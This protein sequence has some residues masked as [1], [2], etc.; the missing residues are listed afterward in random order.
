MNFFERFKLV[1]SGGIENYIFG[2]D[3]GGKIQSGVMHRLNA[4]LGLHPIS[5]CLPYRTYDTETQLFHNTSAKGFLLK[6]HPMHGAGPN[7]D[8]LMYDLLQR[9][10]PEGAMVQ[11]LLYAS[12]R[13]GAEFDA[14][15]N[16]R[17]GRG[18]ILEK[19]AEMRAAFFKKGAHRSIIPG[20]DYILRDFQLYFSVMF[21][22][23]MR[24]PDKMLVSY[25][26]RLASGFKSIGMRVETVE[27]TGLLSLVDELLRPSDSLYPSQLPWN[28]REELAVQLG[29]SPD[30]HRVTSQRI[31]VNEGDWEIRTFK[32]S[33]YPK[34]PVFLCEMSDYIGDLF[35]NTKRIGCPFVYSFMIRILKQTDEGLKIQLRSRTALQRAK[36][37][38]A[39]SQAA[40]EEA[41]FWRGIV[42]QS[43]KKERI[44]ECAFQITLYC[45]KE[46]ADI[47]EA[48]LTNVFQ[49]G[50]KIWQLQK[51]TFLHF[52]SLLAHLPLAQSHHLFN[53]LR[54]LNLTYKMWAENAANLFPM[55]GEIKGHSS[56]RLMVGQRR[57]QILFWDPFDNNRGNYNV[58]ITGDSGSGKSVMMQELAFSIVGT[59]GRAFIVDVGKSYQKLCQLLDG[60]FLEFA[61]IGD[62]CLNPFTN[63]DFTNN[64][65]VESFIDF[66]VP[67]VCTLADPDETSLGPIQKSFV[68]AAIQQV[69]SLKKNLSDIQDI[70]DW[71]NHQTDIRANDI[72][73]M[74]FPYSLKG[75]YAGYFNGASSIDFDNPLVVFELEGVNE[76][77]Q[78]AIFKLL[79]F[80]VTEKMYFGSRQQ[81]IALMIDEAWDMLRG[82]HGAKII[83]HVARRA[84]K[85]K[86][87]LLVAT[88]SLADFFSSPA[89]NAVY[90]QSY[91]LLLLMQK[92]TSITQALKNDEV[93]FSA[94]QEK[95]MR[96]VT[97]EQGEY[98]EIMIQGGNG[99]FAVGR[100]L[101]DP[102]SRV[103]YS[104][105]PDDYARVEALR[106]QGVSM[107]Q[108]IARV[109]EINF[110]GNDGT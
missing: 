110:G 9:L 29:T 8:F 41:H 11:V 63:V 42:A 37:M 16:A 100:L 35:A 86:G 65:Q 49:Q 78:A 43:E 92:D 91:W 40:I 28:P 76:R 54:S 32:V 3:V 80:H 25:R 23:T 17:Q 64:K 53:D 46:N 14:F 69:V 39:S 67:F 38:A 97:T 36:Q 68:N 74:L 104:T 13:I 84:R 50:D 109:A 73:L 98:S 99:E 24:M 5:E 1:I 77:L 27:P 2:D 57:G 85:Y 19:N 105:Q 56:K 52:P 21:D 72:G 83:E 20:Q 15:A 70:I 107:S 61:K 10:L 34:N 96:S 101:L 102:Y 89:G 48:N 62:I 108:T 47:E 75:Q 55:L 103:L 66:M 7:D 31:I 45:K 79:L 90:K 93:K 4:F 33:Q 18:A 60:V 22:E 82:G 12:P 94:F 58:A 87:C 106:A 51:N 26:K 44:V 59:G 6:T 88:Q 95:L 81:Q 71:L 30:T